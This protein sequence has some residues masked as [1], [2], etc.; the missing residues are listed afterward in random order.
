VTDLASAHLLALMALRG[1]AAST[2]YNLGNGR[3][4][5]VREVLQSIARVSGQAVPHTVG[6]RRPGDPGILFASSDRIRTELGWRPQ[7]EE[8]DTI[9]AT[10]WNWRRAHPHGYGDGAGG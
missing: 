10:A 3:A 1:G 2:A 7:F 6:A 4:T 9:V 8:I 5:S